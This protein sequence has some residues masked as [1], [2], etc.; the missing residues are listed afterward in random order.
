MAI[1]KI[2]NTH[3]L[4][5]ILHTLL[6]FTKYWLGTIWVIEGIKIR[7]ECDR[8]AIKWQNDRISIAF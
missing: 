6:D 8:S 4:H 2:I 3:H 5:K 7:S 1:I